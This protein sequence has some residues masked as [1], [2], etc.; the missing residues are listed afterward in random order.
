MSNRSFSPTNVGNIGIP[1]SQGNE[2][3]IGLSTYDQIKTANITKAKSQ[4]STWIMGFLTS[5]FP[6][7]ILP[8]LEISNGLNASIAFNEFFSNPEL[9]FIG[10][11]IAI[12]AVNDFVNNSKTFRHTLWFQI[13]LILIVLGMLIYT[14]IVI[15][16]YYKPE[17]NN[18]TI[19]IIFTVFY[20]GFTLVLGCIRYISNIK[21]LQR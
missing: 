9:L 3:F 17:T 20:I 10:I 5:I 6:L 11:S 18:T 4:F 15:Q 16:N 12:T 14:A 13:N 2:N 8:A 1:P 7:C 21:E 19:L